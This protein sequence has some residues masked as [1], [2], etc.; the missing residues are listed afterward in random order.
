MFAEEV[1]PAA[2]RTFIV[3]QGVIGEAY[4]AGKINGDIAA[5]RLPANLKSQYGMLQ[6]M[7][8]PYAEEVTQLALSVWSMMQGMT[9]LYLYH[10]LGSFLQNA[11]EQFIDFEIE[12]MAKTLGLE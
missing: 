10:Y 4:V 9:S 12:K 5:L 1:G 8:M 3:L 11:V 6:K 2:Q 7:G